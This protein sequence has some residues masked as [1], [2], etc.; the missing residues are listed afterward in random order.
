M[1]KERGTTATHKHTHRGRQV[2]KTGQLSSAQERLQEPVFLQTL[3]PDL[4]CVHL[5]AERISL[6]A[7]PAQAPSR[8]QSSK[9]RCGLFAPANKGEEQHCAYLLALQPRWTTQTQTN[10]RTESGSVVLLFLHLFRAAP[11]GS[12]P[13]ICPTLSRVTLLLGGAFSLD[14]FPNTPSLPW[15]QKVPS[16][17]LRMQA[18]GGQMI[19]TKEIMASVWAS[20]STQHQGEASY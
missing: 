2:S 8:A 4:R 11:A 9:K 5:Q 17:P 15:S 14:L 20:E 10:K 12:Y 19:I 1:R 13:L 6:R 7:A 18:K 3:A 16:R